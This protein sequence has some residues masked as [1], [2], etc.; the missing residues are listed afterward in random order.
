[1]VERQKEQSA[2]ER[3]RES[4]AIF[5]EGAVEFFDRVPTMPTMEL[6]DL[7]R[8]EPYWFLKEAANEELNAR[9]AVLDEIIFE[10]RQASSGS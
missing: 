8:G 6:L 1:M 4:A 7:V 10:R 2:H 9:A 3:R 5:G